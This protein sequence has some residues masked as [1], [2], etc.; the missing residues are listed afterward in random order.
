MYC[1]SLVFQ[2]QIGT[3]HAGMSPVAGRP[4]M[5]AQEGVMQ[6]VSYH[7]RMP[8]PPHRMSGPAYAGHYDAGVMVS[9]NGGTM[10][11]PQQHQQMMMSGESE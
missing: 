6:P 10:L 11:S 9:G 1:L 5:Y 2:E 3:S 4:A 7:A 8:G